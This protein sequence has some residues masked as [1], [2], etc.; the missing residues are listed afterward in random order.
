MG[1]RYSVHVPN[2]FISTHVCLLLPEWVVPVLSVIIVFQHSPVRLA[3]RTPTTEFYKQRLRVQF[4]QWARRIVLELQ[5]MNYRAEIFDPRTGYPLL[6]QPGDLRLDD[7][8]V[9]HASLG[10]P[11]QETGGCRVIEHP[12][13]G[14]AV[15][16]SV[17]LSSAPPDVT[18]A[19]VARVLA[20]YTC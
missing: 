20:G 15:F 14:N 4:V 13:W 7:V 18:D 3:E 1:I 19:V 11:L 2:A 8:A 12:A 10:Y 17:L 6:S 5:R 9:I 16:P